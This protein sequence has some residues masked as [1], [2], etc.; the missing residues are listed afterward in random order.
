MGQ[1]GGGW[2]A[3]DSMELSD[4]TGG[5]ARFGVAPYSMHHGGMDGTM[6]RSAGARAAALAAAAPPRPTTRAFRSQNAKANLP[7]TVH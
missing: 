2:W 3:W 1:H 6:A 7:S 4:H 5:V